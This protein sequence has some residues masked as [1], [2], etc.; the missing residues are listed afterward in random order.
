MRVRMKI[1]V[2]FDT[3]LPEWSGHY[4][5]LSSD[6]FLYVAEYDRDMQRWYLD[7]TEL[8]DGVVIAFAP[9]QENTEDVEEAPDGD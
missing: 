2:K 8:D 5:V 6:G 9:V 7:G 4:Y 3:N 1:K